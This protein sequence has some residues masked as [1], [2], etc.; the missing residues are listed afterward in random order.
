MVFHRGLGQTSK[1]AEQPSLGG[2]I[3][4]GAYARSQLL[5][6]LEAPLVFAPLVRAMP[7]I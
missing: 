4:V 6:N 3:S 2:Q 7:A 1:M 5:H